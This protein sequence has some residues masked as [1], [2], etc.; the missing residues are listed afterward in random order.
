MMMNTI[1]NCENCLWGDTCYSHDIEIDNFGN[2]LEKGVC[3][4]YNPIDDDCGERAYQSD[5]DMR[6]QAYQRLIEEFQ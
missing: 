1:R 3:S 6:F 4:Q 2:I 5:L